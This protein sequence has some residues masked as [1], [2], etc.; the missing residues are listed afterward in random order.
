MGQTIVSRAGQLGGSLLLSDRWVFTGSGVS[1]GSPTEISR[2]FKQHHDSLPKLSPREG[3]RHP[4]PWIGLFLVLPAAA[5]V[6]LNFAGLGAKSTSEGLLAGIG[7]LG[8]LLF[9]VLASVSTR[10]AA[11]ADSVE[12]RPATPYEI[13]L[14]TRLDIARA[15]IA[16]ATLVSIVFVMSL[17][18]TS[19]LQDEPRWLNL[20]HIFFLLHLI[21]HVD[22]CSCANQQYQRR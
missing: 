13:S 21:H 4:W 1:A 9:G 12:G 22:P 6:G 10:I 16:Y 14:I 17:G 11:I 15:N 8:G 2:V 19:M 5:T 7:V 18:V 3:V 20:V